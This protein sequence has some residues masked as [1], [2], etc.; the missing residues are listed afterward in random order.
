MK[1]TRDNYEIAKVN[2]R[3]YFLSF[4]REEAE[5]RPFLSCD[6]TYVYLG[7]AGQNCRV[8]R[9]DGVVELQ[10]SGGWTEAGF[11]AALTVYDL[12]CYSQ[13]DAFP[14][15][16]FVSMSHL[17]NVFTS[18]DNG[19]FYTRFAQRADR[20]QEKFALACRRLGG[21]PAKA[22][23]DFAFLLPLTDFMSVIVQFWESD[24]EFPAAL[25][26]LFD[27]NILR[28]MHFET[29]WYAMGHLMDLLQDTMDSL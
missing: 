8:S 2:A 21:V 27:S 24:E 20:E 4:P 11:N 23:G 14:S 13:P 3:E 16:E 29:V 19:G 12:L 18:G 28:F 7:L 5:R 17:N 10:G 15:G 9:A 25:A 26:L 1:P 6:G 22:P